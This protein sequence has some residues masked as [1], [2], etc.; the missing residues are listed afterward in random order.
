VGEFLSFRLFRISGAEVTVSSVLVSI[1][2]FAGTW[3]AARISGA[4]A[5][6]LG[7]DSAK[8]GDVGKEKQP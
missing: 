1:A 6:T 5:E 4:P 8:T 2:I 3:I 7:T